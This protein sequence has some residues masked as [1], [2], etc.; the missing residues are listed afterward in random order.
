M[1]LGHLHQVTALL[2][3]ACSA[4]PLNILLVV[5]ALGP[6]L[7]TMLCCQ[8]LTLRVRVSCVQ[9][10]LLKWMPSQALQ[11]SIAA[12]SVVVNTTSAADGSKYSADS[13]QHGS[14][15]FV[16]TAVAADMRRGDADR[17]VM[18]PSTW[19]AS[20][21]QVRSSWQVANTDIHEFAW[22]ISTAVNAAFL[23]DMTGGS[24]MLVR[25]VAP[26]PLG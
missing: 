25:R 18:K 3:E 8:R 2:H 9:V 17:T 23:F 1:S 7:A 10:E 21:C 20:R 22:L 16:A 5:A 19:L 4:L 14:H 6:K 12:A 13:N 24:A 15:T 11:L 26:R